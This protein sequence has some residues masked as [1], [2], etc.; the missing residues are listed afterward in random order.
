MDDLNIDEMR[1]VYGD[2][3]DFEKRM[4]ATKQVDPYANNSSEDEGSD[5]GRDLQKKKNDPVWQLNEKNRIL[6][7]RLYKSEKQ[8]N[9]LKDTFE[10]LGSNSDNLK[11]KKIIELSKKNKALTIQAEGLK[12]KAAKAAEYAIEAKKQMNT[13][14]AN[15]SKSPGLDSLK[16]TSGGLDNERKLKELEKRITKMRNEN[17][18]QKITIEKATRLLEREIGEVVDIHELSKEESQWKGRSQKLEIMKQQLKQYKVRFGEASMM[19]ADPNGQS[20]MSEAPSVFTGKITHA[21]RK[22]TKIG[23]KKKEDIDRLKYTIEEQK[24]EIKEMKQKY[25]GAVA[26]RDTLETQL[27]T[28]K[29]DFGSKIKMLLDKTENDDKLITMLKQE[30]SRLENVKGVKSVIKQETAKEQVGEAQKLRQDIVNLRHEVKVRDIEIEQLKKQMTKFTMNMV[31]A[32]DEL[33]EERESRIVELEEKNE[34]LEKKLFRLKQEQTMGGT[35]RFPKK[36]KDEQER[37]IQDLTKNNAILR[38]KVDDLQ[39]KL[40]KAQSNL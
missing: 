33:S 2:L 40:A 4:K 16:A 32:P 36:N 22:I 24:E 9:E 29:T 8:L 6:I 14:E 21:E 26:R 38:R 25:S 11:D 13:T 19:T 39:E 31:G 34:Q 18:E 20:M 7:D 28:I 1:D 35:E 3:N 30:I 10:A 37:L 17:Q 12:T 15:A 23:E 5:E 27:K